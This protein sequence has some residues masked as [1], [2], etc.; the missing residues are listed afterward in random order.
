MPTVDETL[1]ARQQHARAGAQTITPTASP[2]DLAFG[3]FRVNPAQRALWVGGK[4]TKLGA[5]GSLPKAVL[6]SLFE[7]GAKLS[8]DAFMRLVVEES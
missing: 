4:P 2:S 3:R 7:Q 8:E 1:P 5:R 6:G